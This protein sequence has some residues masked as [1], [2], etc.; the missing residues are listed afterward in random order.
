MFPCVW[1]GHRVQLTLSTI[2][3]IIT[4]ASDWNLAQLIRDECAC[5]RVCFLHALFCSCMCLT[6][7]ST[8][9]RCGKMWKRVCMWEYVCLRLAQG[10]S[11]CFLLKA[12]NVPVRVQWV[13]EGALLKPRWRSGNSIPVLQ[14]MFWLLSKSWKCPRQ[15]V[16]WRMDYSVHVGHVGQTVG[17]SARASRNNGR[18]HRD[19]ASGNSL[20][21]EINKCAEMEG[22]CKFASLSVWVG[23]MPQPNI[24]K[25]ITL[26]KICFLLV[27]QQ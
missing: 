19:R 3:M 10:Q 18:R 24:S 21:N 26:F 16:C 13:V 11:V 22:R 12:E 8:L 14:N 9:W 1:V 15:R 17:R 4:T 5:V 2:D 20:N 23:R 7:Q 25:V 6:H 27:S